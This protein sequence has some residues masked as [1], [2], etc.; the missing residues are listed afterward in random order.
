MICVQRRVYFKVE[1]Q[2]YTSFVY[3]I[4]DKWNTSFLRTKYYRTSIHYTMHV[5][6]YVVIKLP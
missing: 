4:S 2:T 6:K 1:W 3:K 5:A